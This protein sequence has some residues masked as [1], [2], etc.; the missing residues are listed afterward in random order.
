MDRHIDLLIDLYD[1]K[2]KWL[3]E[4]DSLLIQGE[5]D[6]EQTIREMI[7]DLDEIL[8]LYEEE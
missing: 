4:A 5:Q 2:K 1:Y 8:V 7:T 6:S 3:N